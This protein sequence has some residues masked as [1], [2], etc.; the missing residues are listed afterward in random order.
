MI[1]RL[2]RL[3][4][5]SVDKTE[6]PGKF[7]RDLC[8][9]VGSGNVLTDPTDCWAYGQDNSRKHKL[10]GA[11]VLAT[12][13]SHV[14][15]TARICNSFCIPLT[16][17]GRG[18]GTAGG[19]VPTQGGIVLSLERMNRIHTLDIANRFIEVEAGVLNQTVQKEA[20]KNG[21][22]WPPDPSSAAFCTV[23]GNIAVNAAGPRTL[24]Y[25]STRDNVLG[26]KAVTAAGQEF[27]TGVHTTKGVVGYDL[28][29][30][31]IGS[32]GTLAIVTDAIL[33]LLPKTE[34][35]QLIRAVYRDI[36]TATQAV[37]AIMNQAHIPASLEFMDQSA[38]A[39]VRDF[40][41]S[42][43]F[44]GAGALLLIEADGP[45]AGISAV[46]EALCAAARNSG[47]MSIERAQTTNEAEAL[48]AAR[49]A[50]SPALRKVAPDKINEDVVV[51]VACI[52][53]LIKNLEKLSARFAIPIVNFGHAGN[54][55]IHVNLLYDSTNPKQLSQAQACLIEVFNLVLRLGGTL[56]GEHGIGQEKNEY[57]GREINPVTLDLMRRIKDQ[58]DPKGI[59]NPG[60]VF[61]SI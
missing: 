21:F 6:L 35:R 4:N 56:S 41:E 8:N 15:D 61:P 39:L 50:L 14:A 52:P 23:G 7:V 32:E 13:R 54:G 18:T 44:S 9:A 11:V 12:N 20:D 19:A 45:K 43:S 48:K 53:E 3:S 29:R 24:K 33:R 58:F 25:G 42:D 10:P 27:E 1:V 60:K 30:L 55:N 22:F 49:K 34:T 17:R 51:P 46:C 37:V 38:I 36:E 26:L 59:L 40:L 28:T 57:I 16:A 5:A 47:L 2:R 31:I